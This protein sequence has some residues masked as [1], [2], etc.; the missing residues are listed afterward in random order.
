MTYADNLVVVDK[1][2]YG[3]RTKYKIYKSCSEESFVQ[4][5]E[6]KTKFLIIGRREDIEIYPSLK[7]GNHELN[8]V[9]QLKYLGLIL[10]EKIK[11]IKILIIILSEN[12]C[13]Y[14]LT[15]ILESRSLSRE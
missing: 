4:I 2:H 8:R 1:L 12:Q 14:K 10:T 15:K 3:L 11:F 9:K 13:L 7:V 5:N 6:D